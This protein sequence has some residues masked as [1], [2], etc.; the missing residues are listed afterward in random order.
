MS[1][2]AYSP[3]TDFPI[4]NLPYGVFRRAGT[5]ESPR[6]GVAIG[7][8]ILDLSVI[9]DA[10]LF[11]GALSNTKLFHQTTLN[12][13]MS[14][15]R[16]VWKEAR[17]TIVRLLS[18]EEGTLRD[19]QQLRQHALVPQSQ[20]EML[21][22]ASIGDYTDF[23]ASK[24]HATNVGSM[25]R[26]KENALMPN[27]LWLP[28]GYHGRASSIVVSGSPVRRPQGQTRP[29]E[30]EP[31]QFGPSR[32]VDYELEMALLVGPGNPL[33]SPIPINSAEDHMF[34]VVL[35]ND[36]SARDIQKW[37]YQPLGP[38][39]AKNWATTI[40]PWV[41]T[42][43]ALEPF[44]VPGPEQNPA[45][46]PYLHDTTPASYD[47]QLTVSIQTPK[48]TTPFVLGRTNFKHMYWSFKQQLTHHSATGC[49]MRPG[50]LLGSGTISGPTPESLGS[51]L[52]LTWGGQKTITIPETGEERKYLQ[53]GDT[54]IMEGWCQGNGYKI[55]FGKCTGTVLPALQ[56]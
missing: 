36:W 26:G 44:R 21:L 1:W 51:L 56:K 28:V 25:W 39:L 52:E 6:I 2:I 34:G 49:N 5:N 20:A 40:S 16:P 53:D 30:N 27:W 31:P 41:V 22:P 23:Y 45:P 18:K 55:G 10:N 8:L 17:T 54:V 24:E 9:A 43:E 19:N 38:F 37:E 12:E 4:E 15:G 50:D 13:F 47:I 11:T 32:V 29:N 3:D 33:G 42:L 48:S 7:D 35:M 14:V 46:L